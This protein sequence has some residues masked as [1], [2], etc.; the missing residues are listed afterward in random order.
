MSSFLPPL[1]CHYCSSCLLSRRGGRSARTRIGV[2]QRCSVAI[3]PGVGEGRGLSCCSKHRQP[4][5]GFLSVVV[6]RLAL[7]LCPSTTQYSRTRLTHCFF[8][9]VLCSRLTFNSIKHRPLRPLPHLFSADNRNGTSVILPMTL[10][11]RPHVHPLSNAAA[12][13]WCGVTSARSDRC[14]RFTCRGPRLLTPV[15]GP[16]CG[17]PT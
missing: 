10:S 9:F 2:Q 4:V 3:G 1:V 5:L 7:P 17:A 13:L 12:A 8:S 16:R 15:V 6:G 11:V 14:P